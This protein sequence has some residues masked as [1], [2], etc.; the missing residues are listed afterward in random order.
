MPRISKYGEI[1]NTSLTPDLELTLNAFLCH[2]I[3]EL[4]TFK[5]VRFWSTLCVCNHSIS[6]PSHG[7]PCCP[8]VV[9]D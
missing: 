6:R 8:H 7:A 2:H 4:Y 3:Q 1:T 9:T 5:M